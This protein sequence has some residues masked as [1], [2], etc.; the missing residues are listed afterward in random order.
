MRK[1]KYKDQL[2]VL[3]QVYG[4]MYHEHGEG[5]NA[6][7]WANDYT[8]RIRFEAITRGWKAIPSSILDVGCGL[9]LLA[10]ILDSTWLSHIAYTYVGI[11]IVQEFI[12]SATKN[13]GNLGKFVCQDSHT[14][15]DLVGENA[16][17]LVIGSGVTGMWQDPYQVLTDMWFMAKKWMTFNWCEDV[18]PLTVDRVLSFARQVGCNIWTLDHSY[19]PNDYTIHMFKPASVPSFW[20]EQKDKAKELVGV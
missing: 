17:D 9:G 13:Y 4:D 19:L 15:A 11:D 2:A 16:Y 3:K 14:H 12:D 10:G 1:D 20:V 7:G 5:P 8:Q 6:V 18:S